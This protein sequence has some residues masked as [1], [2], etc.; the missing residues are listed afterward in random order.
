MF[1]QCLDFRTCV[2]HVS[3]K[4]L[5]ARLQFHASMFMRCNYQSRFHAAE[6]ACPEARRAFRG[7]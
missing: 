7:N 6:R 4:P 1:T 3:C 2:A 5:A